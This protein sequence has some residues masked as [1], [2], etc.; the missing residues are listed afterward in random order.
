MAKNKYEIIRDAGVGLEVGKIIETDSLH[1]SLL[2]HVRQ[3]SGS[4]AAAAAAEGD[5]GKTEGTKGKGKGKGSGNAPIKPAEK[6]PASPVQT[7]T[8]P[9]GA[10]GSDDNT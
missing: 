8:P 1:P 5:D 9:P 3:I 10:D 6:P 2:Q 4:A 7:E